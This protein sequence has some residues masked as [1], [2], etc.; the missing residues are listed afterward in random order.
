MRCLPLH[1]ETNSLP[2]TK[3]VSKLPLKTGHWRARLRRMTCTKAHNSLLH[4]WPPDHHSRDVEMCTGNPNR[5]L[6]IYE[7]RD[8]LK[9]VKFVSLCLNFSKLHVLHTRQ[10]WSFYVVVSKRTARNVPRIITDARAQPLNLLFSSVLVAVVVFLNCV[11]LE[12]TLRWTSVPS[13]GE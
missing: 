3:L 12:V 4:G 2:V 1:T 9:V 8:T 11:L 7:S 13:R 5:S 10:S 6:R